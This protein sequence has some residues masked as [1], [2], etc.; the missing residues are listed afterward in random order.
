[1]FYA[2]IAAFDYQND[3]K[4]KDRDAKF[5]ELKK[6]YELECSRADQ[7]E[8]LYIESQNALRKQGREAFLMGAISGAVGTWLVV[9]LISSL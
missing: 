8:E 2:Y 9:G 1:M 3:F 6:E 5:E 4:M 7:L